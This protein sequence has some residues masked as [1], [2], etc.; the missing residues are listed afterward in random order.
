MRLLAR[1]V[2]RGIYAPLKTL[3]RPHPNFH[4]KLYS[5]VLDA[6]YEKLRVSDIVRDVAVSIAV[7]IDR[8][9]IHRILGV[10]VELKDAELHW[11]EF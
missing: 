2:F 5:T 9:G 4:K 7:S 3:F 1:S 6:G 10:S 8:E 11:K